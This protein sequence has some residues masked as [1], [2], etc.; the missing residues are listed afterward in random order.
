[1]VSDSW[2]PILGYWAL[3]NVSPM[4]ANSNIVDVSVEGGSAFGS[5]EGTKPL[6]WILT[7]SPNLI[8]GVTDEGGNSCFVSHIS[9]F[10]RL[11]GSIVT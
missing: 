5:A 7:L 9:F 1:M 10:L 3:L 11:K 8:G 2:Y 4:L 6:M